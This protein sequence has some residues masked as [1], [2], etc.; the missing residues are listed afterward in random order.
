M[1]HIAVLTKN[2]DLFNEIFY[3]PNS[4]RKDIKY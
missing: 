1:I 2:L 3:Y 4:G